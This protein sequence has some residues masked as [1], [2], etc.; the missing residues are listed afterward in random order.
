[1]N[2]MGS[3]YVKLEANAV[4]PMNEGGSS[5]DGYYQSGARIN[6]V[7]PGGITAQGWYIYNPNS[8][9]YQQDETAIEE[10]AE[11][12]GNLNTY[13]EAW[14]NK[15]GIDREGFVKETLEASCWSLII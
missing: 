8:P 10:H 6:W 9:F 12:Y 14:G 11:Q 7:S 5:T 2:E 15:D 13:F 3:N 1:M 4:M